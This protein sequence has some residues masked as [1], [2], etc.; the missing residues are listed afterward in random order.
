MV[1]LKEPT[2]AATI[3]ISTNPVPNFHPITFHIC[4]IETPLQQIPREKGHPILRK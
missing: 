4:A 3:S 1:N 2:K